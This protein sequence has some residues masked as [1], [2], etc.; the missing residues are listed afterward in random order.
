VNGKNI[1]I[2]T[3]DVTGQAALQLEA[4]TSDIR[5]YFARTRDR[6]AGILISLLTA[7]IFVMAWIWRHPSKFAK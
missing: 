1:P 6:T 2:E 3:T 5:I 7:L 4:G